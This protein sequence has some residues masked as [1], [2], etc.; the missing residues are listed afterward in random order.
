MP[1]LKQKFQR[2]LLTILRGLFRFAKFGKRIFRSKKI[3]TLALAILL[4]IIILPI[5]FWFSGRKTEASWWDEKWAFRKSIQLTNSGSVQTNVYVALTVDTSDTTKFQADCGD[6]RFTKNDGKIMPYLIVSGCGTANTSVYVSFDSFPAGQQAIWQYYGNTSAENGFAQTQT[7]AVTQANMKL[8]IV[9]GTAFVDFSAANVLTNNL[10]S[11]LIIADHAGLKLTGY[12]KAAG[13]GETYGS[14]ISSNNTAASDQQTEANTYGSWYVDAGGAIGIVGGGAQ[15]VGSYAISL[16]IDYLYAYSSDVPAT[17]GALYSAT[18]DA[19]TAS[20]ENCYFQFIDSDWDSSGWYQFAGG[21]NWT[22]YNAY[23]TN[24]GTYVRTANGWICTGTVYIDNLYIRQVLTPSTT[25][26]TITSTQN[27]ST[28]NWVSEETGFNRN[29]ESNYTYTIFPTNFST[30]ASTY[31]VGALGTEEISPAPVGYWSF[32][33]GQGATAHDETSNRNDGTITGATW[34]PES[35][36]VSGK[37]LGFDGTSSIVT[38]SWNA[39]L[40]GDSYVSMSAWV[41]PNNPG[42]FK[43]ILG[44]YLGSSTGMGIETSYAGEGGEDDVLLFSDGNNY[45][46]SD[47]NILED[48]QWIYL[49]MV[50]DGTQSG[51]SGRLKLYKNG[52]QVSINYTGTIPATLYNDTYFTVGGYSGGGNYF[53]GSIDE[54]KIYPYART[55]AQILA[56]YNAGLAGMGQAKTGASAT[57]GGSSDKWMTDGLVGY[58]KMDEASWNGTSGEVKDASGNNN[59]GTSAGGATT[60]GGKFGNGGVFTGTNGKYIDAGDPANGSLDPSNI[61]ISAW[62]K[63]NGN[64]PGYAM[65][66]NKG[67]GN[68]DESNYF[69]DLIDNN[70]GCFLGNSSPASDSSDLSSGYLVPDGVW[71]NVALTYDGATIKFYANGSPVGTPTIYAGGIGAND[72]PLRIGAHSSNGAYPFNG[73]IDETRIYNRALSADEVERLYQWAPGPVGHWKMD[74]HN[75]T[76]IS[77]SSENGNDGNYQ[78]SDVTYSYTSVATDDFN[79]AGPT[80][81]SNWTEVYNGGAAQ[82]ISST[83][84]GQTATSDASVFIWNANSLN[85]DQYSQIKLDTVNADT[86]Y[87]LL[88]RS[89]GST[90]NTYYA[91]VFYD[92]SW[93]M[94]LGRSLGGSNSTLAN[95]VISAPANGDIFKFAVVGNTLKGYINGVEKTSYVDSNLTS[96]S[97][98]FVLLYGT[99]GRI[100][101]WEGGN[102]EN[103][104]AP[105]VSGKYG[106]ALSF[107]GVDDVVDIPAFSLEPNFS[108]SFWTKSK[109]T[110]V[111]SVLFTRGWYFYAVL[112]SSMGYGNKIAF[113]IPGG[114]DLVSNV[115]VG[116]G[117]WH[118]IEFLHAGTNNSLYVDGVFQNS[119]VAGTVDDGSSMQIGAQFG[120]RY[121]DGAIDDFR[122]YNY[123]RTQ[124]QILE[125]MNN[126]EHNPVAVYDFNEGYGSLAHNSGFGGT[127]L[128]GNLGVGS[129]SPTWTNDGKNGKA[130]SFDGNDYVNVSDSTA[131][132]PSSLTISTWLK[133]APND[134]GIIV[135]KPVDTSSNKSYSLLVMN[136]GHARFEIMTG[137]AYPYW[138]LPTGSV[139]DSVW[140]HLVV[141][142]S[143]TNGNSSDAKAYLDGKETSMIY[144]ANGYGPGQALSYSAMPLSIGRDSSEAVPIYYFNGELDDLKIYPYALTEDEIKTDYNS[145][146]SAQMGAGGS[147]STT[148]APTNASSGKYCVPGDTTACATPVGEWKMDEKVAG[149]NQ[150]IY[151]TSGNGNNGTT[152]YGANATGMNCAAQGKYGSAC[153]F[154]GVDDYIESANNFAFVNGAT[155]SFWLK[156]SPGAYGGTVSKLGVSCIAGY[157]GNTITCIA[158]GDSSGSATSSI[159]VLDN[160]WHY[161]AFTS[162]SNAQ[163]IYVDGKSAGSATETLDT[164]GY[165]VRFGNSLGSS[166]YFPGQ[167]D[168]VRIYDYARTPAQIAWEYNQGKPVAAWR[169]NECQGSTVHDESGNG[170][171]GTINLGASGQTTAGTCSANANTPWYNGR[172]GKYGA[173]LNFDGGD[174]YVTASGSNLPIGFAPRTMSLWFNRTADQNY[175]EALAWYGETGYAGIFGI[176]INDNDYLGVISYGDDY[177]P[178]SFGTQP[179]NTW[180]HVVAV[181][182]GVDVYLY[183]NGAFMA[184][185]DKYWNLHAGDVSVGSMNPSYPFSGQIDEVKIFNYALTAEQVKQL[186]NNSSALNFQ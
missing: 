36:C 35:E 135:N 42:E 155:Y 104:T 133:R 140:H 167:I 68:N 78:G 82:I 108:I 59:N 179:L 37:C 80:L 8:S 29:D 65:I 111:N 168:Q 62:I 26:A 84:V 83:T 54:P 70:L 45:G 41:K 71:T 154:D 139:T 132:R 148:G 185:E 145:G 47:S 60:A 166:Y 138:D 150:T 159:D 66:V 51:N 21:G 156:G 126:G 90:Q 123:A 186:Y 87:S 55:Q 183:K 30:E 95:V 127:S 101:D 121:F 64:N 118:H 129:S 102:V 147:V 157:S 141:T 93:R 92:G 137:S 109:D 44:S 117:N 91:F 100:D 77:D 164:G 25:G 13:S 143:P 4:V 182:D 56:D 177:Y 33:E 107:N 173:S 99:S 63:R 88:S 89:D 85:A 142:F 20:G 180:T 12:V 48:N 7:G 19:R 153:A 122:I 23:L 170:N 81:G 24:T 152:H 163:K 79:R 115:A 40:S 130:L 114:S 49:T 136:D 160:K 6:L 32:D 176:A 28:F 10:N 69:L 3:K 125:D 14:D 171:D 75:G 46:W 86:E 22:T 98:G 172:T 181:Y 38:T 31:S 120:S 106:T 113:A 134:S 76:T 11:K 144:T 96:G 2:T 43:L 131:L 9:N 73:S 175:T 158:D 146:V 15:H 110:T 116:G 161:V 105:F 184:S 17:T 162:T 124:Q 52:T 97:S 53:T 1:K 50:F 18:F 5:Y 27:G 103:V 165:P 61:T 174:D 112:N 128:A 151:D 34:K 57:F 39:P 67:Y 119:Q 149:D 94:I 16:G 178:T 74:D 58:W 72:Y 169:F